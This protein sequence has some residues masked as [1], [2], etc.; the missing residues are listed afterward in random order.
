M[1]GKTMNIQRFLNYISYST[2]CPADIHPV[3]WSAM[4]TWAKKRGYKYVSGH[5]VKGISKNFKD[6]IEIIKN[7]SNWYGTNMSFEFYRRH[8]KNK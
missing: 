2:V 6:K 4:I 5:V 1:K 8:L 7:F 3:R